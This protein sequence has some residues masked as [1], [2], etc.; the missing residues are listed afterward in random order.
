M[1]TPVR[2]LLS[3]PERQQTI[4]AGAAA[5]FA[6]AGF[7]GTSMEDVAAASGITKLIVYRHFESKAELYRAV[8]ERTF[9]RM[10]DEFVRG[11][12][13]SRAGA[14]VRAVL[15]AGREQPDGLRLLLRH[16]P[17]EPAFQDY[18]RELRMRAVDAL[19]RRIPPA[20]RAFRRWAAE[21]AI[22]YLWESVLYWLELGEEARDE[23]FVRRCSAG[24]EAMFRGFREPSARRAEA[25][26]EEP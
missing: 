8:L 21:V 25:E 1:S 24:L 7:A 12:E 20:D 3:R 6:Q 11:L 9:E 2:Q 5:A 4:L 14:G 15:I 16:A 23:E 10:R 26:R 13:E 22:S 19:E 17:R 18:A